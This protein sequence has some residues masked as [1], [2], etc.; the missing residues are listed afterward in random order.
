[1]TRP[2]LDRRAVLF[3]SIAML[4]IG[5]LCSALVGIAVFQGDST[6]QASAGLEVG[7]SP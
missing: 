2:A 3:K 5:L 6:R 1:M 4:G 7:P